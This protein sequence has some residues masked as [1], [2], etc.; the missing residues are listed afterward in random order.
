MKNPYHFKKTFKL[1]GTK[2]AFLL[3][4]TETTSIGNPNY[5]KYDNKHKFFGVISKDRFKIQSVPATRTR[6]LFNPLIIGKLSKDELLIELKLMPFDYI[7]ISL[8]LVL[9]IFFGVTIYT[10]SLENK[11]LLPFVFMLPIL[12]FSA[13]TLVLSFFAKI[14]YSDA[15]YNIEHIINKS[16]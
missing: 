8:Y 6:K 12:I 13:I 15:L 7:F 4:L 1:S 3:K 11:V 10:E 16:S 9:C 14:N 5:F 2:G